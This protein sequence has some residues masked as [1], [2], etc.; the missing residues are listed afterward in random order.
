MFKD[1]ADVVFG[2]INLSQ[3]A[4]RGTHSPGAGGWPTIKYFN[5]ETGIEGAPYP[6]KTD[7]SMCDELGPKH[8]YM[9]QYVE[10]VG[11]ASRCDVQDGKNCSEKELEFLEK[12]KVKEQ[13]DQAKE[14]ERLRRMQDG[15]KAPDL[16]KWIKARFSILKKLSQHEEL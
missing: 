5:S 8:N 15:K 14:L 9:Q 3:D 16:Q 13:P 7:M 11:L 6:K 2:D 12:W 10:E 4:V 1:E